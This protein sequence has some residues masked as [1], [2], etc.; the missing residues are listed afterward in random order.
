MARNNNIETPGAESESP[1]T[2]ENTVDN[3]VVT[4]K[5]FSVASA[6]REQIFEHFSGYK[7]DN[8]ESIVLNAD[9][10]SLVDLALN[11]PHVIDTTVITKTRDGYSTPVL[12]EKGWV[13]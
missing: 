1:V 11:P 7:S 12:T 9:F 10:S 5:P 4:D 2:T 6:D 3:S 8:G 13:V